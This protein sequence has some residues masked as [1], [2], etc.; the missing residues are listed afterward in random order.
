MATPCVLACARLRDNG[1]A[2]GFRRP[3]ADRGQPKDRFPAL[4]QFQPRKRPWRTLVGQASRPR[5]EKTCLLH[6]L[7]PRHMGMAM[8]QKL[9]PRRGM[10]RRDMDQMKV[11]AE[12]LQ[13]H[14]HRPV[15]LVVLI[16]PD[17]KD[18]GTKILDD[19]QRRLL[20]DIAKVPDFMG[21]PDGFEQR[22][23]KP[24]VGICDNGDAKRTG[25]LADVRPGKPWANL[26]RTAPGRPFD[27]GHKERREQQI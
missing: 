3:S 19:V 15:G 25:H 22:G 17:N 11:V 24:V 7:I 23:R 27:S 9:R 18:L 6:F 10:A 16:S 20:A 26:P 13:L 12:A 1:Y 8:K 5:I 4:R 14:A 21:L 2:R